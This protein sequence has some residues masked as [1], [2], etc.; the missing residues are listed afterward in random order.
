[1][2]HIVLAL[3]AISLGGCWS[4]EPPG[5]DLWRIP[6]ILGERS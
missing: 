5:R 1:M 2:K 4:H 3:I 6:Q